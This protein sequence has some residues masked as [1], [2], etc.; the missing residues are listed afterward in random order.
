MSQAVRALAGL[1][2]AA[3]AACAI[4]AIAG[5]IPPGSWGGKQ[6]TLKVYADSATLDLP[7]AVGRIPTPL[8]ADSTGKFD[9]AGF[10]APQVGPVKVGGPDW[11]PARFTGLRTD[12]HIRMTIEVS[13]SSPSANPLGSPTVVS[14]TI[15]P[16]TFERGVVVPFPRCL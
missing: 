12:D 11:E 1:L 16:L 3:A 9:V 5:P 15:G 13:G 4:G 6:G 8:S 10:Y 14:M 7:C 2:V